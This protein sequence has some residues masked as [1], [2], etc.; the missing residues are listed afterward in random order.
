M[1][2][3]VIIRI[4]VVPGIRSLTRSDPRPVSAAPVPLSH[5]SNRLLMRL[6]L[7]A[8]PASL[9]F[10]SACNDSSGP[11]TSPE[12]T[13]AIQRFTQLADSATQA[14]DPQ[15]AQIFLGA[16]D[17][18]R[19]AGDVNTMRITVDG[20]ASDYNALT[21]S[22]RV[23]ASEYCDE[24]FGCETTPEM[25]ENMLLA[26]RESTNSSLLFLAT[27][28]F[29]NKSLAFDTAQFSDT[30]TAPTDEL[31]PGLGIFA[32]ESGEAW[33]STGGSTTSSIAGTSGA[34]GRPQTETPGMQFNCTKTSFSWSA[35]FTANE[36]EGDAVGAAH[37][38]VVPATVVPGIRIVLQD[39]SGNAKKALG[40]S[41][42][43]TRL[44]AKRD[45]ALA[46]R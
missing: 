32:T 22:M 29:G 2:G 27:N 12:A 14:G 13:S 4:F 34:C 45:K 19:M 44:V 15:S 6:K 42:I 41:P 23:P 9:L 35:S 25:E 18:V 26:W 8:L 43:R 1:T 10:A 31:P 5:S 37:T 20:V 39:M 38:I 28:G 11:T 3:Y 17:A 33:F 24:E 7:L 21:L 30:A 36:A 16:A 40:R 46:L